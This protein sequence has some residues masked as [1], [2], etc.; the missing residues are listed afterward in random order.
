MWRRL[1]RGVL[2]ACGALGLTLTFFL[3]LPLT[4]AIAE[5]P[6]GDLLVSTVEAASLPPP[7]PP[8]PEQPPEEEPEPEE[9]PP[10]LAEESQPLD[11]SQLELALEPM[12][13]GSGFLEGDFGLDLSHVEAAPGKNEILELTEIDQE[14]RVVYQPPPVIDTR[15]RRKGAGTVWLIF[16]VDEKGRVQSPKV[17]SSS[18]PVFER[19]ALAA[20][21]QWRFEPGRS[22]GEPIASRL[23]IPITF[24]G[25]K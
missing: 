5:P 19:P 10:E 14:P 12:A 21:K 24:P 17:Q 20:V 1:V 8:P 6:A 23:R 7:P 9:P 16:I 15:V 2:V 11:L 4:Q 25:S 18:D 13:F 22:G 3:V